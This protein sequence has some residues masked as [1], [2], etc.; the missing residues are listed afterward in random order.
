MYNVP[1][2][3]T[4]MQ[5]LPVSEPRWS[6]KFQW[7]YNLSRNFDRGKENSDRGAGPDLE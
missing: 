4:L 6:Q 1:S 7:G 2:M 3:I 5:L